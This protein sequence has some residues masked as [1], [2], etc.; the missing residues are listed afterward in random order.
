MDT[1]EFSATSSPG[2]SG[3]DSGTDL[4]F[5]SSLNHTEF[6]NTHRNMPCNAWNMA[7]AKQRWIFAWL[8]LGSLSAIASF[9]ASISLLSSVTTDSGL[10]GAC[11]TT[12]L[13][14]LLLLLCI[15]PLA[16][17]IMCRQGWVIIQ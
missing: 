6:F 10:M 1:P 14:N 12:F 13:F 3:D 2:E 9:I 16:I 5:A 4:D 7:S 15:V 17:C 8:I 11:M